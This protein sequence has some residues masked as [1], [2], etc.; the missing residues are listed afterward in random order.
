MPRLTERGSA[1]T[2]MTHII[3]QHVQGAMI[4]SALNDENAGSSEDSDLEDAL[5]SLIMLK[6]NRYLAPRVRLGRA[7]E[8]TQYLFSLDDIRFKQEFRMCQESFHQLVS[9]IR[10]HPVFQNRSNIPQRPVQDQL[11]VTL[12]R[13]GTYGNGASVG[14][15]YVS[16]P[17]TQGRRAIAS[18]VDEFTGFRNCVGFIDGTLLPLYDRPAIDPQDYYSRKGYYCLNTLIVCHEEKRITYYLTGWPGCCHDTRLWENSE[19]K[20]KERE[21]FSPGEYLIANSGFPV[22][23]NVVPAFKRP[24][25]AAMPQL[26]K[27]FNHHLS[28]IRISARLGQWRRSH[29]I[30]A[31]IVLHNFLL[32]DKTPGYYEG[33]VDTEDSNSNGA[34]QA[35]GEH[36]NKLRA[37]VFAEVIE[38]LDS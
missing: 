3:H 36:G 15:Q 1:I 24:P 38:F 7:P 12:K 8:I 18:R 21:L 9:E 34:R 11:M 22:Q 27:R 2:R 30:L 25:H 31:C 35:G 5:V 23:T 13:M 4:E 19:L 28:S 17:D 20:L 32:E 6:K 26:K 37:Q 33:D 14:I 10:D 16:W 29:W